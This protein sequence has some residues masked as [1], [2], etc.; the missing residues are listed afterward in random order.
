MREMK[1]HA[2]MNG[3]DLDEALQEPEDVT[4]LQNSRIASNEGFGIGEGLG[5]M[6]ME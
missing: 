6:S 2:A 5:F 3:V 1:F 4:A